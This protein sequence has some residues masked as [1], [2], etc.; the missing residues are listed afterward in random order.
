M[1]DLHNIFVLSRKGILPFAAGSQPE[2]TAFMIR[3]RHIQVP[4]SRSYINLVKK[5]RPSWNYEYTLE[6]PQRSKKEPTGHTRERMQPR[7]CALFDQLISQVANSVTH[8]SE[9]ASGRLQNTHSI[10]PHILS[11]A[12]SSIQ[13]ISWLLEGGDAQWSLGMST[14]SRIS[15]LSHHEKSYSSRHSLEF[16]DSP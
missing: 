6:S 9:R 8:R 13:K 5:R 15:F 1:E 4:Y 11:S 3:R 12:P 10:Y 14:P 2:V 16:Q 7:R